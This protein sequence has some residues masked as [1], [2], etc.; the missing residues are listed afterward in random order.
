MKLACRKHDPATKKFIWTDEFQ[1]KNVSI[2]SQDT[3]EGRIYTNHETGE[4]F[5]SVTSMLKHTD[6]S[7]WLEEWRARLGEEAAR[8]ESERC[9]DRGN[10]IHLAAELYTANYP[11]S[12]Q[13]SA[14]GEYKRLFF[15]LRQALFT[16][17]GDIVAAEMPVMSRMMCV[18]GKFDLLAY[19]RGELALIDYKGS[20]HMKTSG[21]IPSYQD[22]LCA[23]SLALQET[24][25]VKASR[26]V[27]IIAN[28]KS[29]APTILSTTRKEIM[30]RL[31]E[32]IRRFKNKMKPLN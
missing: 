8:A 16:H 26:L 18:G 24:H 9:K 11:L 14:C 1:L 6:D 12:A 7:N 5:W 17:V 20:N 21:Q 25:G 15:Q 22:Q 30:P 31:A 2:T 32:R 19:W 13:L 28:E 27:N 29:N 23:Y 4:R 10:K 3:S